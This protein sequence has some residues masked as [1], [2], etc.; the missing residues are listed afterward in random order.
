MAGCEGKG[1]GGGRLFE[2]GGLLTFSAF[3]MGAFSRWALIRGWALIRINRVTG[4]LAD[5]GAGEGGRI[6]R[7]GV[8]LTALQNVSKNKRW[9]G[10]QLKCVFSC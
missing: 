9:C 3:R 1:G 2:A 4:S 10:L 6:L 5:R 7:L 8:E